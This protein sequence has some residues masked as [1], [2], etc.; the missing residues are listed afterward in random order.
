M[1]CRNDAAVMKGWAKVQGTEGTI[2]R[3]MADTCGELTG[4]LGLVLC[5]PGAMEKLGTF[6]CQRFAMIIDNGVI[7]TIDATATKDDPSGSL[8]PCLSCVENILTQL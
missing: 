8:E 2:V 5:H 3:L 7:K 4:A 6:R 1:G